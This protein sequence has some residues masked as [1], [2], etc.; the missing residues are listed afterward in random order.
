MLIIQPGLTYLTRKDW[1]A[2]TSIPRLGASVPRSERTEA[3]IH[4]TVIVDSDATK[5]LWTNLAEVKAKMRQLQT[6]RPDLG[7]DVPYNFVMFLMED[8]T[9]VVCEGRGLDLRGAHTKYHNRTGIATALQGNFMLVTYQGLSR[10]VPLISRWWGWVRYDM[11]LVNLGSKHPIGRIAFGHIDLA[12]TSCPGDNLYNIIPQLTF[13]EKEDDMLKF[14]KKASVGT[15]FATDGI[16]RWG[17]PSMTMLREM[18]AKGLATGDIQTVSD[19]LFDR[20]KLV[21]SL[22]QPLTA[23]QTQAEV[24]KAIV[25]YGGKF[26]QWCREAIVSTGINIPNV[27]KNILAAIASIR[28]GSGLTAAQTVDAVKKANK[29]GTG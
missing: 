24:K 15:V 1:G 3:I 16:Y 4:H 29:E 18:K 14:I 2:D 6:I 26:R 7:K 28:A 8:G 22:R 10:F 13:K 9:V 20:I 17:I 12:A 25:T 21:P 27:H 19:R 23:L 11:K 5:N